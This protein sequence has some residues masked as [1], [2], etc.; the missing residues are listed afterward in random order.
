[1]RWGKPIWDMPTRRCKAYC[2]FSL[3][4][5]PGHIRKRLIQ[6]E[7]EEPYPNFHFAVQ[8]SRLDAGLLDEL[9]GFLKVHPDVGLVVIDT[10]QG[11]FPVGLWT[12]QLVQ[13]GLSGARRA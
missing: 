10:L 11:A 2:I 3:E 1:M 12:G 7:T 4:D 13:C 5:T 6:M 8:A 9:E